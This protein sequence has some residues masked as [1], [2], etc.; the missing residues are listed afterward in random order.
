MFKKVYIEITNSCNFNCSFC[1]PSS[2]A[3]VLMSPQ[4]FE[5]VLLRIKPF[6]RYIYLHVLG[7]PMLHP[8]FGALLQLAFQHGFNVNVTSNG[9]LLGRLKVEPSVLRQVRQFNFSLHD[10]VEN[11]PPEGLE[12]YL[13]GVCNFVKAYQGSC[14]FS[15]RLW[16]AGADGVSAFNRYCLDVLNR[17]FG[18]SMT[19]DVLSQRST[20]LADGIYLKNAARFQWPGQVAEGCASRACYALRDHIAILSDGSVVPC[21]LDADAQLRLGNIFTDDLQALLASPRA[22]AIRKGFMNRKA[23]ETLCQHC[24][25]VLDK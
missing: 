8:H 25:F 18:L 14:Y 19:D 12:D 23:V 2:R 17:E 16:N 11:I 10:A 22:E 4:R 5:E 7:E 1:F 15:L 21:C 9:S 6:T 20:T 13:L 24:G 3:K